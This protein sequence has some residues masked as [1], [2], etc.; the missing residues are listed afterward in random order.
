MSP[1][2]WGPNT[3][4]FIHTLAAKI[5]EESF[6]I[7]GTNLIRVIMSICS[8]LPCPE[9]AQH[10][11]EFWAKVKISNIKN[12]I[13]LINLLYVFHNSVNKRRKT[14]PFRYDNLNYYDTKNV[15]ETY[16]AFS[17]TFNTRGNL[18]L[19]NESFHRSLMMSSL[20]SWIISNIKHFEP[21]KKI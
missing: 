7:I 1:S 4:L 11:K 17:K 15:I 14:P 6:P 16:N 9:C 12:K 18:Q 21:P 3:W 2:Y 13:D 5:K 8:N 19:I 10:S 20:R